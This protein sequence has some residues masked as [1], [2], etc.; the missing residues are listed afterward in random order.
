MRSPLSVLLVFALLALAAGC[1][2]QAD[3]EAPA[4][5]GTKANPPPADEGAKSPASDERERDAVRALMGEGETP[6]RTKSRSDEGRPT[7]GTTK[8]RTGTT[9]APD[10]AGRGTDTGGSRSRSRTRS[11]P[12]ADGAVPEVPMTPAD[13]VTVPT[14]GS[15]D[16][17]P[18]TPPTAATAPGM[19]DHEGLATSTMPS[20][21]P[22]ETTNEAPPETT[23][24]PAAASSASAIIIGLI[25]LAILLVALAAVVGIMAAQRSRT[26]EAVPVAPP[27]TGW[28]YLSAPDAPSISLHKSPFVIGSAATCD[29]RLADPKASPQHAR[30]DHTP[31][32]HVL[33][34]LNST[35]GTF[36]NGERIASPVSLRPGDEV[37]MGDIA[38][39]FE[40]H[41]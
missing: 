16:L 27:P 35:N 25:V 20:T 32:G 10:R 17:P 5:E 40:I 23:P 38:V 41:V 3:R 39:T 4:D 1:F 8:G 9:P 24:Q 12:P 33:T 18:E 19:D 7:A 14:T 29:L 36:L 28:A 30:I 15:N 6:A 11:E 31:D 34:D 26:A 2:A 22:A 37:Q 13:T 21:S